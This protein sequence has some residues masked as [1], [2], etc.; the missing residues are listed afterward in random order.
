MIA[1]KLWVS[2]YTCIYLHSV[3]TAWI[4]IQLGFLGSVC[5]VH[6]LAS[7]TIIWLVKAPILLWRQNQNTENLKVQNKHNWFEYYFQERM[8]CFII[9]FKQCIK[10]LQDSIG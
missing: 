4:V 10:S 6:A 8:V 7:G 3:A 9:F 2:V 5:L 1:T